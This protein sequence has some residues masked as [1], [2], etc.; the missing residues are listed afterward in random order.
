MKKFLKA[1]IKIIAIILIIAALIIATIL[2]FGSAL[3]LAA[4]TITTLQMAL[5]FI[6]IGLVVCAIISPDGTAAAF[7]TVAKGVKTVAKGIGD[8]LSAAGGGLAEGLGLSKW[9]LLA[10]GV[11]AAFLF[12]QRRKMD[13][14]SG[15]T[16]ISDASIDKKS[17]EEVE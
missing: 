10:G 13:S 11:A 9:L 4:A 8:L 1:L 5:V 17:S 15:K 2:S 7:K 6:G 16:A 3:G 12:A 14:V